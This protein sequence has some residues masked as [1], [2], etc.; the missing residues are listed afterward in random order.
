MFFERHEG[1]FFV[2]LAQLIVF[3]HVG[4]ARLFVGCAFGVSRWTSVFFLRRQGKLGVEL[5]RLIILFGVSRACATFCLAFMGVLF[6]RGREKFCWARAVNLLFRFG[7]TKLFFV[8]VLLLGSPVGLSQLFVRA[9]VT[10]KMF[11]WSY[12]AKICV[13]FA[14]GSCTFLLEFGFRGFLLDFGVL[15]F[16]LSGG[17]RKNFR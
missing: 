13:C 16:C 15:F 11:C 6:G 8:G 7:L 4:L 10:G 9:V 1:K 17:D 14:L 2:E 5:A 3:F 12:T